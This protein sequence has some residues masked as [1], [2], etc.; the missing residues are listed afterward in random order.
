MV[1]VGSK[2]VSQRMAIAS[3]TITMNAE[4]YAA[5]S[6]GETPKGNVLEAARIAGVMAAKK[7]PDIIPLCHPLELNKIQLYFQSDDEKRAVHVKA[8]VKYSGKTGVEMEALTA[9]SIAALTIYD[10]MK[11]AD[12]GML[13]GPTQL[14]QKTG[15]KSGDY[16]RPS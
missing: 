6:V 14:D 9:A 8:E 7:T 16:H 13:I 12:R 5:L 1:D 3:T 15:G 2:D 10:M 4:A 11:W